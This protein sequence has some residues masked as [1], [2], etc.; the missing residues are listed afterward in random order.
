MEENKPLL[1]TQDEADR[2]K[3]AAWHRGDNPYPQLTMDEAWT[4]MHFM[5]YGAYTEEDQE[6]SSRLQRKACRM[7]E[8][9]AK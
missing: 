6:A 3:F 9:T 7:G 8:D 4:L 2:L 1:I 5:R